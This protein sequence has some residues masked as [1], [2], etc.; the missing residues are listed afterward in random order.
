M[1][2]DKHADHG[3]FLLSP[4]Q[5]KLILTIHIAVSVG[6]LGDSAGYLAVAIRGATTGDPALAHASYEMLR[7]FAFVFGVPLSF[8][9]LLTGLAL[10]LGTGGASFAIRGSAPSW[11]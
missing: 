8:A 6:L 4:L 7:M 1:E 5:R 3:R 11:P 10:G 2:Q 9:A